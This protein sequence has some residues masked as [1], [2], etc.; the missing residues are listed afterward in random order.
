MPERAVVYLSFKD[1]FL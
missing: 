1:F